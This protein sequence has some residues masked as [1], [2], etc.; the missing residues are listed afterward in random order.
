MTWLTARL[1]GSE[2]DED[3]PILLAIVSITLGYLLAIGDY[4][5]AEM[6]RQVAEHQIRSDMRKGPQVWFSGTW[7]FK[8]Y[9]ER[10]GARHYFPGIEKYNIGRPISGDRVYLPKLQNWAPVMETIPTAQVVDMIM[11]P[12]ISPATTMMAGASY[13]GTT[14]HL[15]PWGIPYLVDFKAGIP[16]LTV[17][18]VDLVLVY[19]VRPTIP[20]TR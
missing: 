4:T 19:E 7:G 20:P 10:E 3:S 8:F 14:I 15:L 9:A 2:P 13:Y 11:P 12:N 17:M 16:W 18:P 6:N 1:A 5:Y